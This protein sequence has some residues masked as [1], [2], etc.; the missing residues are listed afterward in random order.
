M[1]KFKPLKVPYSS[2]WILVTQD[3]SKILAHAKT[4]PSI[5]KKAEEIGNKNSSILAAAKT[6]HN[7]V[8]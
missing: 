4:F 8:M 3:H 2:G 5:I 6:Y 7:F 1:I